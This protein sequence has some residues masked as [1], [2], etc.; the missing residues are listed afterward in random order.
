MSDVP[1]AISL[2]GGMDSVSV[3][4][5]IR[6]IDPGIK[7]TSFTAGYEGNY[8]FDER[9]IAH[10]VAKEFGFEHVEIE[11]KKQEFI[12]D[13]P[14]LVESM[15]TPVADL[16][17]YPQFRIAQAMNL[18]GFRVGIL[19]I[20]GD[21]LF[22]GYD[23]AIKTLENQEGTLL[24]NA[25][26]QRHVSNPREAFHHIK[27]TIFNKK[28]SRPRSTPSGYPVFYEHLGDFNSPFILKREY[29]NS[30]VFSS[31]ESV[32]E[33][34][35]RSSETLTKEINFQS[36]LSDSWLTC[37]S[38]SLSDSLGM[39][40]SVEYR[41]PFLDLD[42]VTLSRTLTQNMYEES[43]DK[44]LLREA[45]S[46]LVPSY[47]RERP[48]SGFRFPSN[49]WLPDLLNEYEKE[50]VYGQLVAREFATSKDMKRLLNGSKRTWPKQFL[51]YKLLI[52]EFYLEKH[53]KYGLHQ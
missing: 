28:Y 16:A 12:E 30:K 37:N 1:I 2:S 18:Q 33:L 25:Q 20:G 23:W 27:H 10:R 42:L 7:I 5:Q 47:V 38:L 31:N 32:Y 11:I 40:N 14:R 26:R 22:W 50:L 43:K 21:E 13:F 44:K 6:E 48:K 39:E 35:S 52:L 45:L 51:L 9:K 29:L 15:N 46:D 8:D 49:A 53:S 19:G 34:F 41:L 36:I 3:A 4:A 24:E 17:A